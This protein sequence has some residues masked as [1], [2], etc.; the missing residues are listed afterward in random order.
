M[1]EELTKIDNSIEPLALYRM[2]VR[3]VLR[4]NRCDRISNDSDEHAKVLIEEL[5]DSASSS[6]DVYCHALSADVWM[7]SGVLRAIKS[8][9][10]RGVV[11]RI[12]TQEC[13]NDLVVSRFGGLGISV[14]INMKVKLDSNFLIVDKKAFRVEEDF[15]VRAGFAYAN[16]PEFA[17]ILNNAFYAIYEATEK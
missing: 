10:S 17:T 3:C 12:V 7:S 15:R 5:I 16:K 4:E 11:F 9:K 13:P 6:V 1:N 2:M 8:A 14:V